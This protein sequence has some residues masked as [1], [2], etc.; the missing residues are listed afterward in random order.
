MKHDHHIDRDK[1]EGMVRARLVRIERNATAVTAMSTGDIKLTANTKAA[2][3][4]YVGGTFDA[5]QVREL[6]AQPGA[7]GFR[8]YRGDHPDGTPAH[9]LVAVDASGDDMTEMIL[10]IERPCPPACSPSG[11]LGSGE[12]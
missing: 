12:M 5:A 4:A 8:V 9:I 7:E 1:A 10:E 11:I 3:R 6:L 2:R